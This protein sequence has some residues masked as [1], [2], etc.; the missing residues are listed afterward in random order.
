TG[1]DTCHTLSPPGGTMIRNGKIEAAPAR[2]GW[3]VVARMV[4]MIGAGLV[5]AVPLQGQ[6]D[7]NPPGSEDIPT[8]P[9][10]NVEPHVDVNPQS[11]SVAQPAV[12]VTATGW[13]HLV[14][15]DTAAF[16]V[17]LNG[18]DVTHQWQYGSVVSG[19]GTGVQM[20]FTVR[21]E[22]TL[23]PTSGPQTVIV[24]HCDLY[25]CSADTAV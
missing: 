6:Q 1:S 14:D 9:V 16:K 18:V 15:G 2:Q 12:R 10:C 17:L 19:W 11:I 13:D 23:S 8:A 21:G 5:M 7:C 24:E 3:R 20:A 25:G 22:V 4:C